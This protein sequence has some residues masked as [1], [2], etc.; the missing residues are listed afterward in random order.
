MGLTCLVWAAVA[1]AAGPDMRAH[2]KADDGNQGFEQLMASHVAHRDGVPAEGTLDKAFIALLADAL[3]PPERFK[4]ADW[5]L[6]VSPTREEDGTVL[7]VDS[8][9]HVPEAEQRARGADLIVHYRRVK[10]PGEHTTRRVWPYAVL[11]TRGL[12]GKVLCQAVPE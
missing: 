7:L 2:F 12:H 4:V 9:Q 1:G 8:V 11:R 6:C 10:A 3:R 5:V